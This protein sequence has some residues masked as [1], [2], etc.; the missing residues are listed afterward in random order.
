MNIT[1]AVITAAGRS[2][3]RLPTQTLVDRDGEPRSVLAIIL[4]EA[5]RAGV[6]DIGV[7]IRPGDEAAYRDAAGDR[8]QHLS[9]LPQEEPLGYG[10]AVYCARAFVGDAPFLHMVG[11]HVYVSDDAEGCAQQ[12]VEVAAAQDCSVSAVQPTRE[13]LLPYFG[14][15]GGHRVRHTNDR[16]VVERVAEKPTPTEA[17]QSL[18]IPGLRAG[19]YLCFFGMH[20]LTPTLMELLAYHVERDGASGVHLSSVLDELARREQYMA[21]EISGRRYPLDGRYGVLTAQLA[22]ALSGRDRDDVLTSLVELLAQHH[23]TTAR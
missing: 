14:T 13:H 5:L 22:L 23:S 7:V 18:M 8:A 6:Q 19:H 10:H 20:V 1:K 12:L 4:D 2:Q 21:F 3:R 15:V 17:E 16:Y 9:F 11:D